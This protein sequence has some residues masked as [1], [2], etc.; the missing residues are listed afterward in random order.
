MSEDEI[1]VAVFATLVGGLT[2]MRWA[3]NL[4]LRP[5]VPGPI[6][7]RAALLAAPAVALVLVLVILL[8]AAAS[9]VRDD[10]RYLYLYTALGSAWIG[11]CALLLPWLGL[12]VRDDVVERH[13]AAAAL[14]L[15]GYAPAFALVYAGGNIGDGPGWWVVV[16]SSGLA[17]GALLVLQYATL[18]WGRAAEHVTVERD[19][20]S[21]VRVA[22][23]AIAEA[24]V[25]GAA[26]AGDW[27]SAEA[28]WREFVARGWPALALALLAWALDAVLKPRPG[29]VERS[30]LVHGVLPGLVLVALGLLAVIACGGLP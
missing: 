1:A 7:G 29:Q 4:G 25:L 17:T 28:T 14:A 16:F 2:W 26:V 13:N 22:A 5:H 27:V 18:G 21:G 9:D 8:L 20:A 10:L 24:L 3:H 15:C 30:V 12:G 11:S 23:A 6:P 19:L